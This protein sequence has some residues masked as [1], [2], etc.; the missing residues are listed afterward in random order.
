MEPVDAFS[1]EELQLFSERIGRGLAARPLGV[2]PASHREA[3]ADLMRRLGEA[4]H[5]ELLGLAPG[6]TL[7]EVHDAYERLA[8]LVHPAHAV[9]LGLPGRQGLLR[10]LFE[11]AT[12]AYLVLSNP[13]RRKEYDRGLAER[14]WRPATWGAERAE[15]AR[16]LARRYYLR[17]EVLAAQEEYYLA[18]GLLRQAAAA[19]PRPEYFA[20]L[21]QLL[22]R[23]P[24]W[25][26][27]AEES[28]ARALEL[29]DR[30][31][32]IAEA[33]AEVRARRQAPPEAA[34]GKGS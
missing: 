16:Q 10:F 19:D 33:L 3:L 17:A 21:G 20:L 11:S 1:E 7:Q 5:Y 24:H 9:R 6:A 13:E 30:T 8:R 18:I 14:P 23:N 2:E 26:A 27:A 34:T 32:G 28:L 22:S 31:P 15:E 29:G 12:R 25:L 4:S